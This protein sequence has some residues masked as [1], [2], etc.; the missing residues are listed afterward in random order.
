LIPAELSYEGFS[1]YLLFFGKDGIF[2][3]MRAA[4][5]V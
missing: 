3:D 1:F 4:Q 5:G 2:N